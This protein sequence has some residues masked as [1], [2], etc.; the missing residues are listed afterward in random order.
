MKE[1]Q[2]LVLAM[3]GLTA[4]TAQVP[5]APVLQSASYRAAFYSSAGTFTGSPE[6][7]IF[8]EDGKA[9]SVRLPFALGRFAYGPRGESIYSSQGG[10]PGTRFDPAQ[11]G[12][13]KIEFNPLRIT[14]VPGSASLRPSTVLRFLRT[15]TTFWSL[16][17]IS[18]AAT[19]NAV[20]SI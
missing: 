2:G 18:E 16:V 5:A 4:I 1:L 8:P 3:A 13:V 14:G 6:P 20:S 17:P 10:P 11:P 7:I 9:F 19:G 12:L 15:A